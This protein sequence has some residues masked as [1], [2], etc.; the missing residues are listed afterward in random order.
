MG[1]A[2]GVSLIPWDPDSTAHRKCLLRQ[3]EECG[4]HQEKVE[5]T[6]RKE[7][8]KGLKCT[9]WIVRS[10]ILFTIQPRGS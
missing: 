3:R 10:S 6:W 7:Q 2:V 9:Y 4:W 8:V 1:H 5:T